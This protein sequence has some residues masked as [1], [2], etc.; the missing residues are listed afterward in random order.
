LYLRRVAVVMCIQ[1]KRRV[2]IADAPTKKA[3]LVIKSKDEMKTPN[4]D[5]IVLLRHENMNE[6]ALEQA[7]E[8]LHFILQK[9][10]TGE[11][12]CN[13]HELVNRNKITRKFK[14]ILA[15]VRYSELKPFQFLICKN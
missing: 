5:I 11:N 7:V 12:F 8:C 13:A 1:P 2:M 14:K 4:R 6:Q 10:E 15:A 3:W 9:T